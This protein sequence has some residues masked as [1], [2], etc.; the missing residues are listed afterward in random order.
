MFRRRVWKQRLD[1]RQ[2]L[3]GRL[4]SAPEPGWAYAGEHVSAEPT[5]WAALALRANHHDAPQ[6]SPR[7]DAALAAL[8]Q[9]QL[10]SGG[11]PIGADVAEAC[12][13]TPIALLAWNLCRPERF[14]R[15]IKAARA[16]L[17]NHHGVPAKDN[18]LFSHDVSLIGWSWRDATHSWLEPTAISTLALRSLDEDRRPRVIEA[19]R[20]IRDRALPTGG[21]NYGNKHVLGA[22]LRPFPATTG[23]AL[24]SLAPGQPDACVE[25]GL[26]YLQECLPAIRAPWS[27]AWGVLG[28]K[29]W[30]AAPD[31]AEQWLARAAE[32]LLTRPPH[33]V[34]EALLLLAGANRNILIERGAS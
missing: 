34:Y 23:V 26:A 7:I 6:I 4:L 31:S 33:P 18:G 1:W 13:P 3:I 17:L 14:A 19:I 30:D 2:E 32:R 15:Q 8:A 24:V 5:A 29:A 22:L 28:L 21:W 11:V 20:L 27:L 25:R 16:W 10:E 12:W 9:L